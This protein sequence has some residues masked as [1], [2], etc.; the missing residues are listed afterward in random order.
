MGNAKVL[1]AGPVILDVAGTELSAEDRELLMHPNVGGVILFARNTKTAKQTAH[2]CRNIKNIRE[3]LLICIDQEGGRVQ[4]LTEGVTTIPPMAS[5]SKLYQQSAEKGLSLARELGWLLA[6]EL[7]TCGIDNTLAPV[8]DLDDNQNPAIGSR[9]FSID[10]LTTLA[11]A[12]SFILGMNEAGMQAVGKHFPGHGFVKVDSHIDLPRDHRPLAEIAAR[13]LVP[14]EQ[15][16]K[17]SCLAGVMP[18]H[19][20]FEDV[21]ANPVGF[22]GLWLKDIL[23][24]RYGFNGLI[25][26]DDLDMAG[27]KL[28][29]GY[30]AA[31]ATALTAGCDFV[32]MCNNRSGATEI[33][34]G[35]DGFALSKQALTIKKTMLCHGSYEFNPQLSQRRMNILERL[36]NEL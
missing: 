6:F 21:D 22:S 29:G 20:V 13:D 10:P 33:V 31:A 7:R 3:N 36:A 15:L 9:S 26:S 27:A 24:K 28:A 5:L 4:R 14:F 34:D 32:L 2:L 8:L 35:L 12:E 18:A 11:L 25:F 17:K 16:I 23:R 19:I 1:S 30:L